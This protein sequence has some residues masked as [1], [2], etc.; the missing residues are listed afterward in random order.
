MEFGLVSSSNIFISFVLKDLT[1]IHKSLFIGAGRRRGVVYSVHHN[2]EK[3]KYEECV[4]MK[5]D[6]WK[7]KANDGCDWYHSNPERRCSI[8]HDLF[9][10]HKCGNAAKHVCS[11]CMK[12]LSEQFR[13]EHMDDMK[14][15]IQNDSDAK[16][17]I[18]GDGSHSI[19]TARNQTRSIATIF[20][21]NETIAGVDMV[22]KFDI[23]PDFVVSSVAMSQNGLHTAIG[24]KE[25]LRVYQEN[26]HGSLIQKGRDVAIEEGLTAIDLSLSQDGDT[27]A[28]AALNYTE[29]DYLNL[30]VNYVAVY[31]W[32]NASSI[33]KE[34]FQTKQSI[35]KTIDMDNNGGRV[36]I[37]YFFHEIDGYAQVTKLYQYREGTSSWEEEGVRFRGSF[38]K[39]SGNGERIITFLAIDDTN[40]EVSVYEQQNEVQSGWDRVGNGIIV[41]KNDN[42][43]SSINYLGNRFSV[44]NGTDVESMMV[45]FE[46]VDSEWE[47]GTSS[48]NS[49]R[50]DIGKCCA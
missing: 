20:E 45:L 14:V 17:G 27:L 46:E 28:F 30:A 26:N 3:N 31:T 29:S 12:T 25:A 35:P 24:G 23:S 4:Q 18:S 6:N 47:Q 41:R 22:P 48:T 21:L 15:Y 36:V 7:D 38:G 11:S 16:I 40:T 49:Q 43:D 9:R 37:S 19:V 34:A 8:A 33:W 1:L 39:I 50:R 32:D 2:V 10:N 5:E 13:I 42:Y 44:K